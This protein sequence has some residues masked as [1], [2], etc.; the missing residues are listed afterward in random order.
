MFEHGAAV[1]VGYRFGLLIYFI[2]F[3]SFSIKTHG[4][5]NEYEK[6]MDLCFFFLVCG[7]EKVYGDEW[8]G[9]PKFICVW[10]CGYG[11][12]ICIRFS[13][14]VVVVVSHRLGA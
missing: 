11:L 12:N 10:F 8:F 14:L 2:W 9:A 7:Y 4:V 1:A 13:A 6:V 3:V 5:E